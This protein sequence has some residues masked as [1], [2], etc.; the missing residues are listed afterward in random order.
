MSLRRTGIIEHLDPG[1]IYPATAVVFGALDDAVA[2]AL[3][4]IQDAPSAGGSEPTP[5]G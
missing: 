3:R 4:W 5:S 1:N 2:D